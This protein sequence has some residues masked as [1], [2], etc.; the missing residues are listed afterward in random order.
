M[1]DKWKAF[2]ASLGIGKVESSADGIFMKEEDVDKIHAVHTANET[3]KAELKAEKDSRVADSTAKD[4]T[5][6][7]LTEEKTTLSAEISTLTSENTRLTTEL[8][9]SSAGETV[10]AKPV[11]D[12]IINN[13][14]G[15]V[16]KSANQIAA[17][18]NAAALRGETVS[19][20]DE[21]AEEDEEGATAPE[22]KTK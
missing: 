7:T 14:T 9:A 3:L 21:E 5:I 12:P 13:A 19:V 15:K 10:I 22:N 16:K 17:D 1:K 6:A 20:T 4:A 2:F 18:K 8:A 11:A